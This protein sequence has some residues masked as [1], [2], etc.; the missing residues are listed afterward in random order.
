[1]S[2]FWNNFVLKISSL[3][4]N[5]IGPLS[6]WYFKDR[7]RAKLGS[8]ANDTLLNAQCIIIIWPFFPRFAPYHYS[9]ICNSKP[10]SSIELLMVDTLCYVRAILNTFQLCTNIK[11]KGHPYRLFSS[12]NDVTPENHAPRY[13][14]NKPKTIVG[15]V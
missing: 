8:T 2:R 12:E 15:Y 5:L 13:T 1:M 7:G 14:K 11:V 10:S 4:K 6:M 9:S 3:F